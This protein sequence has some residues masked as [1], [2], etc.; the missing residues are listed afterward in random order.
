MAQHLPCAFYHLDYSSQVTL[1]TYM[2]CKMCPLIHFLVSLNVLF[3][4]HCNWLNCHCTGSACSRLFGSSFCQVVLLQICLLS[5]SVCWRYNSMWHSYW[6]SQALCI[7]EPQAFHLW[8][9][10]FIVTSWH[11]YLGKVYYSSVLMAQ[12]ASYDHY[13]GMLLSQLS[14]F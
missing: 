13:V 12:Y 10:A 14:P 5:T 11:C 2:E 1:N 3:P 8:F 4:P 7:C 9:F 6:V